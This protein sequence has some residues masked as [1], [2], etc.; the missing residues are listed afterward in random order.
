VM[1][2]P[3]FQGAPEPLTEFMIPVLKWSD[4]TAAPMDAN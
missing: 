1:L 2:N 4:G 3:Q